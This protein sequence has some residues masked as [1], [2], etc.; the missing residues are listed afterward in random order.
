MDT[1]DPNT[2]TEDLSPAVDVEAEAKPVDSVVT[3]E[4]PGELN[5]PEDPIK[6]Y[7]EIMVG[8]DFNPGGDPKVDEIKRHCA[9]VIDIIGEPNKDETTRNKDSLE[10]IAV[11]QMV[12]AQMC[13]VK[14]ITFKK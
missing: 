1:N 11:A 5:A 14:Y 3:P 13:A 4:E 8:L 7:G 2:T 10:K 9:R 12:I 6:T